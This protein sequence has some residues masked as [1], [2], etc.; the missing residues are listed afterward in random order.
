MSGVA[1]GPNMHWLFKF[2]VDTGLRATRSYLNSVSEAMRRLRKVRCKQ[3]GRWGTVRFDNWRDINSCIACNA[4]EGD[5]QSSVPSAD[6]ANV[7]AP[8]LEEKQRHLVEPYPAK[9][10]PKALITLLRDF[11]ARFG[12]VAS[13]LLLFRNDAPELGML[14]FSRSTDTEETWKFRCIRLK[15]MNPDAQWLEVKLTITDENNITSTLKAFRNVATQEVGNRGM[16]FINVKVWHTL[17][18][19]MVFPIIGET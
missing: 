16:E 4:R 19:T 18:P 3:C 13:A 7:F 15:E 10:E 6:I 14:F 2:V 11:E 5:V 12:P 8:Q 1:S 9:G 17:V